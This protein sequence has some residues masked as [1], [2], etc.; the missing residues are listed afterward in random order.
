MFLL[1]IFSL[2]VV[3][4]GGLLFGGSFGFEDWRCW[5]MK[6]IYVVFSHR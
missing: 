5:F 6:V 4:H 1:F 3:S 2:G